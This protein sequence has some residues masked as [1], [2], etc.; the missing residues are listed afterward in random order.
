MIVSI[1]FTDAKALFEICQSAPS[2]LLEII[3]DKNIHDRMNEAD[4]ENIYN[5]CSL[6]I[7]GGDITCQT[8][9]KTTLLHIACLYSSIESV[10]YLL[11]KGCN[12]SIDD[13]KEPLLF[14]CCRS[15][16][17]P[18][19]KIQLLKSRGT[20]LNTKHKNSKTLLHEAC[21]HGTSDCVKYLLDAG[22]DVNALDYGKYTPFYY[23]C[24]TGIESLQ[25]VKLLVA[26]DALS[27]NTFSNDLLNTACMYSDIYVTRYILDLN[28]C[29]DLK[30]NVNNANDR[31]ETPIYFCCISKKQP[32]PKIKLLVSRGSRLDSTYRCGKTLLHVACEHGKY[33]CIKCLLENGLDVNSKDTL[34]HSPLFYCHKSH[35]ESITKMELL[36]QYGAKLHLEEE[37]IRRA[38]RDRVAPK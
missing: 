17:Q 26:S 15:S 7:N 12:I 14:I 8:D 34:G 4:R 9:H 21:E 30:L 25:K 32:V 19:L 2:N 29:R 28:E 36:I 6:L 31:E 16:I 38:I 23:C 11:N 37:N 33:E 35:E 24:R 10:K 27:S 5:L 1:G 18:D 13:K 20:D 22:L 3:F